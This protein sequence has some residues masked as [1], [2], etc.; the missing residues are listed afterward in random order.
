MSKV[1]IFDTIFDACYYDRPEIL[2]QL[3]VD[4]QSLN[5]HLLCCCEYGAVKTAEKLIELGA[6][7]NYVRSFDTP[8]TTAA[9]FWRI[10]MV[11]LLISK[12]GIQMDDSKILLSSLVHIDS[13]HQVPHSEL[14]WFLLNNGGK[15]EMIDDHTIGM[16]SSNG[17][18]EE[19]EFL[20]EFGLP[21]DIKVRN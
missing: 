8:I 10:S 5:H 17:L 3:Q 2:D 14:I 11:K 15:I 20:I 18:E 13:D 21:V 7:I 19:L 1:T 4:L 12:Y 9:I 6:N 16:I